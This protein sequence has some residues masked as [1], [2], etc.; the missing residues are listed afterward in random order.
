MVQAHKL[1]GAGLCG[2]YRNNDVSQRSASNLEG[3]TINADQKGRV[4]RYMATGISLRKDVSK[5]IICEVAVRG[6]R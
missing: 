2:L 3:S 5:E 4:I 6:L 1:C